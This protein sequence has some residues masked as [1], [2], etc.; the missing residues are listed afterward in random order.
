MFPSDPTFN[1][2]YIREKQINLGAILIWMNEMAQDEENLRYQNEIINKV[3]DLIEIDRVL[4]Y[5]IDFER[6][7]NR[8]LNEAKLENA[9]LKYE[10]KE[11][12][13][14]ID[15]LQNILDNVAENI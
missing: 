5:F 4:N 10:N 6:S 12:A 13:N 7:C 3:I 14:T 2:L 15:K 11:M 9:K 8:F 1:E